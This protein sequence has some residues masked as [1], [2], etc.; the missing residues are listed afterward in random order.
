METKFTKDGRKLAIV[1]SLNESQYIVQEIHVD[2][3]KNEVAQGEK[4]AIHKS[5]LS[6][7]PL[8]TW[9]ASELEKYKQDFEKEK[10]SCLYK[11]EREKD[12][13]NFEYKKI[14][15]LT[16]SVQ[17]MCSN[18][19][20]RG[21]L[22]FIRLLDFL[23][24]NIKWVII[25]DYDA[26][27]L[28][29]FDELDIHSTWNG[30]PES[31]KLFTLFGNVKG[32][33]NYKINMYS[34]GSGGNGVEIIPFCDYEEAFEELKK[35]IKGYSISDSIIEAANDYNIALDKEKVDEF[36]KKRQEYLMKELSTCK[37]RNNELTTQL[38][39]IEQKLNQIN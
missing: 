18:L 34:D 19:S 37:N 14:Y 16:K 29:K 27:K 10:K 25:K 22:D 39:A 32:D 17:D 35:Q 21:R 38:E 33:L 12:K 3:N 4:F 6:D 9:K 13:M 30:K 1:E 15:N 23:S 8:P 20:R 36:Y 5:E 24:G 7:S 2:D 31:I 26:P 11:I 28:I